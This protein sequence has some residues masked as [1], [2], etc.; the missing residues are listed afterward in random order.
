MEGLCSHLRRQARSCRSNFCIQVGEYLVDDHRI[1][2]AG[3]HFDGTAACNARFDV[4]KVSNGSGRDIRR[5][6]GLYFC[7]YSDNDASSKASPGLKQY[8][9]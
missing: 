6:D 8:F 5:F 4:D 2:N 7:L 1:F 3:D 9:D